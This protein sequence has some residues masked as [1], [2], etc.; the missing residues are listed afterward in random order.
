[1]YGNR[2]EALPT[3]LQAG[4]HAVCHS[5]LNTPWSKL[6]AQRDALR[7]L[8]LAN[9]QP[10][11]DQMIDTLRDPHIA[12]DNTLPSTGLSIE[13]EQVLSVAFIETPDYVTRSTTALRV[14]PGMA[15]VSVE[16]K[17]RSDD[18]SHRVVRP[19]SFERAFGFEVA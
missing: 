19:G 18:S 17:E 1:M 11:L 2:A 9:E 8:I 5:L 14:T 4:V 15:K 6:V 3:L 12:D 13:R 7:D 10:T 16:L